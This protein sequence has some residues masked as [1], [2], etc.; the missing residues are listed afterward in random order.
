M[1]LVTRSVS[2][3]RRVYGTAFSRGLGY[4]PHD[5]GSRYAI[6][7]VE[8][9]F[10]DYEPKIESFARHPG[11]RLNPADTAHVAL[12]W[13]ER[14]LE[15]GDEVAE[16]EF[17]RLCDRLTAT[18]V[19]RDDA[20]LWEYETDLPKYGVR[21]PWFS[22]LAQGQIA[23]VYVRAWQRTRDPRDA[24]RATRALRPLLHAGATGLVTRTDDGPVLEEVGRPAPTAQILNGWIFALWGI[25]DV[26]VGLD[27][28]DAARA[29]EE[30][31]ECLMRR[32]PLYDLGWWTLYSMFPHRYP[33]LAKPFYQRL[34]VLQ[35][36]VLHALTGRPV[37]RD[38][39]DRWRS[40]DRPAS[41]AR[42]LAEKGRVAVATAV[43]RGEPG[44]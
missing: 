3:V 2:I 22:A 30:G 26:A 41:V 37:F 8:G 18:A 13:Y 33:D 39:A 43:S 38:T 15:T 21:A 10:V 31:I 24:T 6:E 5:A 42:A 12:G 25:R 7:T 4:E 35:L 16:R 27:A 28:D 9:Y 11:V 1:Q 20:L 23:S 34:H 44:R 14:L 29:Y 32:L 17:L 19:E 36:D 40:Y